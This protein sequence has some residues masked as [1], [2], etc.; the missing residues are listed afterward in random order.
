MGRVV[1]MGKVNVLSHSQRE[2]ESASAGLLAGGA[3]GLWLGESGDMAAAAV[4][5]AGAAPTWVVG[6]VLA[7]LVLYLPEEPLDAAALIIG[8]E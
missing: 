5:E 8:R 2:Q 4:A 3:A 1:K 7:A 6:V